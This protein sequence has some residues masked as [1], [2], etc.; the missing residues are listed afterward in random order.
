MVTRRSGA[1][2]I[3]RAEEEWK[4]AQGDTGGGERTGR[5][6]AGAGPSSAAELQ[7][8][9]FKQVRSLHRLNECLEQSRLRALYY[10]RQADF[11]A[12]LLRN[13]ASLRDMFNGLCGT[14]TRGRSPSAAEE[15]LEVL[16]DFQ[17]EL[18]R[19]IAAVRRQMK[20]PEGQPVTS[21][22]SVTIEISV[23]RTWLRDGS[24]NFLSLDR[25]LENLV[26]NA[27]PARSTEV[28]KELLLCGQPVR[29]A[30]AEFRLL[31]PAQRFEGD[32]EAA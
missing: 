4:Y 6:V 20:L 24:V 31:P 32:V 25:A 30:S 22:S 8:I 2:R 13:I 18:A 5:S 21:A 23:Q 27:V 19:S 28:I 16:H 11:A 7:N 15:G 1:P 3:E 9:I 14:G 10:R 12:G 26:E 29:T 17:V